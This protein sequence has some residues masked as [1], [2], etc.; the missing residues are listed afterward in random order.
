MVTREAAVI[1]TD[2]EVREWEGDY[3]YIPL[4]GVKGKKKWLRICFD[5]SRKQGG[6]PSLNSCLHKGPD[7][8]VNNVLSVITGFRN[9]RVGA[10]ADISKFHN[11]VRLVEEDWMMQR[12]LWRGMDRS[13]APRTY[14][15][16]VNNFGVKPA[17]C[18]ATCALHQSAD[19]FMEKLP[20]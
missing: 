6:C 9:G 10:V 18:I 5:A 1:L 11:K 3:Y 12:F 19:L 7:R 14:A 13:V 17:N 20:S 8:F 15:V 4:V 2:Q 16:V